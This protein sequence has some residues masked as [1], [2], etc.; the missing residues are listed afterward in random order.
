MTMPTSQAASFATDDSPVATGPQGQRAHRQALDHGALY[1]QRLWPCGPHAWCLVGNGLSNQTFIE[2]PEGLI[3]VDTGESVEEMAAALRALRQVT[4][5]PVV[6]VIYTHFHYINGTTALAHDAA[7]RW[8][9]VPVWAHAG[10]AGNRLRAAGEYSPTAERGLVHQFGLLLPA[11]G[12]DGLLDVGLG[13]FFRNP[14]HAPYTVGYAAP[15]HTI[16]QPTEARIAGLQV[17]F[18]PAPSDSNDSVTL[19]LP[20]LGLCVN[21][22]LWPCLFNV[23]PIRGEPYRDP[24][25]LLHGLDQVRTLPVD[26]LVGAHGPPMSGRDTVAQALTV[27]RDSIQFMWDQTVRSLNRGLTGP[28]LA[29]AVAPPAHWQDQ[30]YTRQAYGLMEHHLR[31][32]RQGLVGWFD[33]DESTLFALPTGERAARLIQGFGG[34]AEVR[35]QAEAALQADDLRWAL[36]LA[37]WLVRADPGLAPATGV[38][39]ADAA[40]HQL[41][42]TALRSVAQRTTAQ[43]LR[44]W[45]LTRAL[46]LEGRLDL[47][48]FRQ[49]RFRSSELL[50]N[51]PTT[52]VPV[53]RVLLDPARAAGLDDHL[54]WCFDDGSRTGLH[55][56][57]QVA[58]PTDGAGAALQLHLSA[59]TWASVLA[60]KRRFGEALDQGLVRVVGDV[61]QV[62]RLLGC[63]DLA[64]LQ[65]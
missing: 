13:R 21:N 14:A 45:C 31:Q 23:F 20:E 51:P 3:A 64:A 28:E 65:G 34:R 10:V 50:A 33:G 60:G 53:L 4:Q 5:R 17:H 22:L 15:T 63:F 35:R 42:A 37:S 26:H 48:R 6:A 11:E 2:G 49:H 54:A 16:D 58:V 44:N 40:D 46:E 8:P 19:W 32:I 12:Q 30:Y 29:H 25:V 59:D 43:N 62:R 7:S 18:H 47:A 41:L 27:Y 9:D 52:F 55:I 24:T 38:G 61:A 56:R 57:H 39:L 36:E 1:A